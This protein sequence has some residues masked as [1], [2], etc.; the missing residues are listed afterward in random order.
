[1][2]FGNCGS[3]AVSSS[4]K[5]DS[6]FSAQNKPL[7]CLHEVRHWRVLKGVTQEG[8]GALQLKKNL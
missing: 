5:G 6:P 2:A 1:M 7:C 4:L 3:E 8:R